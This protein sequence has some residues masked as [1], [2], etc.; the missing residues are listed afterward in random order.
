MYTVKDWAKTHKN[1]LTL[2]LIYLSGL[3]LYALL[4][5]LTNRIPGSDDYVF[6]K[7]IQPYPTVFDWIHYRYNSWS[8]RIF[9]E[10]FVYIFSPLPLIFWKIVSLLLYGLF[11]GFLFLY[12]T[13]YVNKR[14]LAKDGLMLVLAMTLPLL[15]D[16]RV[17]TE[18]MLWVT[19]SMNYF[20]LASFALIAFYPF[21]Y[22]IS[23]EK[24][25]HLIV[26]IVA[27]IAAIIASTSQEQVGITLVVLSVLSLVYIL[28]SN[29][30]KKPPVSLI[31]TTLCI[32]LGF[33]IAI[34]AP[35]NQARIEVET[36][37][38]LP[39]FYSVPIYQHIE[40]AYR[41]IIDSVINRF[42]FVLVFNWLLLIAL[43]IH[44]RM[45]QGLDKFD[46]IIVSTLAIATLFFCLKSINIVDYWFNFYPSWHANASRISLFALLPWTIALISTMVAPIV[47][48]R[49]MAS[50]YAL[51][52]IYGGAFVTTV[53]LSLSPSMYASGFR[54]LYIPCVLM[55]VAA[56]ILL[57]RIISLSLPLTVIVVAGVVSV[58]SS[59]Y[60]LL[61][62]NTLTQSGGH[63]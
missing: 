54:I 1:F 35:G 30:Y 59:H 6:Q 63:I 9:A 7:Q 62:F 33:I 43:F 23:K 15:M 41:W 61:L 56:Y 50:A 11:S 57:C 51:S 37:Y 49:N 18:G 27:F 25:P 16:S 44:K 31:V 5:S 22:F 20:W 21:V 39:D 55:L 8:G 45:K 47:L 19:G 52:I 4:L 29:K 60:F 10:S 42:G 36:V 32:I 2:V 24:L 38:R 46:Y 12:Y 13:L 53:I 34:K 3:A 17:L 14:S 28:F 40:Y 58:A 48:Y 26:S